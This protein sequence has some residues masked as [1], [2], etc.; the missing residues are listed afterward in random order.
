MREDTTMFSWIKLNSNVFNSWTHRLYHKV[1]KVRID[2]GPNA[3][4]ALDM[5]HVALDRTKP[6]GSGMSVAIIPHSF[7]LFLRILSK[8]LH[9]RH[10]FHSSTAPKVATDWED[11]YRRLHADHQVL[12]STCTEQEGHIRRL[13]LKNMCMYMCTCKFCSVYCIHDKSSLD[14][15]K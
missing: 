11:E 4:Q 10:N 8:L 13:G 6:R 15:G 14:I 2:S 3:R 7:Y 1:G 5:S 9:L 12:K